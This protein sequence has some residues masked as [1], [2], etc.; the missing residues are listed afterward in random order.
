MKKMMTIVASLATLAS[1]DLSASNISASNLQKKI[2]GQAASFKA[3]GFSYTKKGKTV[4]LTVK[5]EKKVRAFVFDKLL[6]AMPKSY[7]SSLSPLRESFLAGDEKVLEGMEFTMKVIKVKG[8][9]KLEVALTKLPKSAKKAVATQDAGDKWLRAMLSG[10][11]FAYILSYDSK[12]T[13]T[14]IALK[15]IV[16]HIKDKEATVDLKVQGL[17]AT[18]VGDVNSKIIMKE[19]LKNLSASVRGVD[20]NFDFA[21]KN[22]KGIL[23]QKTELDYVSTSSV[24]TIN[25]NFENDQKYADFKMSGIAVNADSKSSKKFVDT[26]FEMP[27]KKISFKATEAKVP[28]AS[29]DIKDMRIA[30]SASHVD[31]ASM[32]KLQ[33]LGMNPDPVASEK[34]MMAMLQ[35]L[36]NKGLTINLDAFNFKSLDFNGPLP[37]KIRDFSFKLQAELKENTYDMKM[38]APMMLIPFVKITGRIAINTAD[39]NAL[40]LVQPMVGMFVQMQKVEGKLSVFDLAFVN[41]QLTINGQMLPF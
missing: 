18:F 41:G 28:L 10:G 29:L 30:M 32:L 37:V 27:I 5:Q 8:V 19:G 39:L 33:T 34:E 17:W 22:L 7:N 40:M 1:L 20:G 9:A 38:G 26:K 21:I 25:F 3:D 12:G 2:N 24:E 13:I 14:G 35:T 11:R 31:K 6:S 23:N 4:V 15:D 16:E 36:I